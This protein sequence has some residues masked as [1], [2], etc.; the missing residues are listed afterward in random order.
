MEAAFLA[1]LG[2]S[3][4]LRAPLLL[5]PND[6]PQLGPPRL[7]HLLAGEY[8]TY[9]YLSQELY[10]AYYSFTILRDPVARVVS[11]YNYMKIMDVRQKPLS[12]DVFL[13]GWLPQQL[14]LRTAD[15]LRQYDP[16]SSFYFVRP[17]VDF[18]TD[19][20][21]RILVKDVFL[22]EQIDDSFP[23]IKARANL[24]S[25][26]EHRNK[27]TSTVRQSDLT[28]AHR[29]LIGQLYAE[30]FA[31]IEGQKKAGEKTS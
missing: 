1:D 2:L 20:D 10:D 26:L 19:R 8:V 28:A 17:Q 11:L 12:F 13:N 27:S 18:V 6:K 3:W 29:A 24:R 25:D 31:F 16:A 7:A 15:T 9:H 4:E 30:D 21:G 5:R 22:L 14:S 23:L